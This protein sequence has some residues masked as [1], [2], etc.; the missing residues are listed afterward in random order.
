MNTLKETKVS[1]IRFRLPDNR[2]VMHGTGNLA[3]ASEVMGL[4]KNLQPLLG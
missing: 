1:L 4:E 2:E 3:R